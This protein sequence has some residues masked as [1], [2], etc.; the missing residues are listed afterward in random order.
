MHPAAGEHRTASSCPNGEE[1]IHSTYLKGRRSPNC[2]LLNDLKPSKMAKAVKVV[3]TG[4][5]G[6]ADLYGRVAYA[7]VVQT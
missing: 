4:R 6:E 3:K 1:V 2:H 5:S 7:N